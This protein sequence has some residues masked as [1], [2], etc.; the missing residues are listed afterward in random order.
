[1]NGWNTIK[2]VRLEMTEA[3]A[4]AKQGDK[5]LARNCM[6]HA[7]N[8]LMNYCKVERHPEHGF[9]AEILGS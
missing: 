7:R 3:R 9:E 6:K 8:L 4:L 1:M 2:Q 5:K